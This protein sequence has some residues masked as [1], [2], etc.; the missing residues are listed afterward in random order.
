MKI[1]LTG[2]GTLGSA[3]P[4]IATYEEAKKQGKRWEWFWIGTKGGVEKPFVER[5]GISYEWVPGAKLRRYFSLRLVVDP[6]LF[7]AA[8]ARSMLILMTTRPD[9]VLG[10]GSFVSVPV[11]WAAKLFRKKII[12][13]QQDIRPTLSNRLIVPIADRIT[14][15]FKKSLKDFPGEK[16]EWTGNPVR[17][18]L[19]RASASRGREQFGLNP[20]LPALLVTGGS[21]GSKALNAWT[22]LHLEKLCQGANVIHLVGAAKSDASKTHANYRQR[23]LLAGDMP[24]AL[25]AVDLVISRAGVSTITELSFLKKAA[26]LVPMPGTHQE[27]NARYAADERAALAYPQN[28]LDERVVRRVRELLRSRE[29]REALAARMGALMKR[30]GARRMVQII[31]EL[32]T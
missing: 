30:G 10:A 26:I 27:D 13:H 21:S 8:L 11:A 25:A 3:S 31:S 15:S 17:T 12:I 24:H 6:L 4:L 16:T 9:V 23:E 28:Q 29:E 20:N 2:G 5:F 19:L 22:W 7:A 14:V 32:C 18:E 1:L